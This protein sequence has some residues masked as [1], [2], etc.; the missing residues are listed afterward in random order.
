MKRILALVALVV[1]AGCGNS[2]GSN[3]TPA[4]LV[5]TWNTT[6]IGATGL[7]TVTCPGNLISGTTTISSCVAG[8]HITF[9]SDG[10][11]T[12]VSGS[13]TSSGTFS[14]LMNVLT[15]VTT[16]RGGTTLTPSQTSSSALTFTGTTV[17]TFSPTTSPTGQ[18]FVYTKSAV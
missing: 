10:H 13:V 1:L 6:S 15:L 11:F 16:V 17:L 4:G 2:P 7:T 14:V 8:D 3:I 18:F 5:G 9:T 12:Q